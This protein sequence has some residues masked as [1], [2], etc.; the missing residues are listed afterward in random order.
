MSKKNSK[1]KDTKTINTYP[2]DTAP[3]KLDTHNDK[4]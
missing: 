2:K 1:A 3:F 4:W